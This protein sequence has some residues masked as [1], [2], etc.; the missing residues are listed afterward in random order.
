MSRFNLL[1]LSR[2]KRNKYWEKIKSNPELYEKHKEK[3]REYRLKNIY[4]IRETN[5]NYSREMRE[6]AISIGQC[7]GCFK[8]EARLGRK[9]CSYCAESARE[10]ARKSYNKRK[11]EQAILRKV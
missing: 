7:S 3:Q 9:T 10:Y 5:L 4:K 8:R 11:N 2:E 6:V 1:S